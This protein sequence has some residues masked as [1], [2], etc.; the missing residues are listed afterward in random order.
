M[1]LA[2]VTR[3]H[4][5]GLRRPAPRVAPVTNTALLLL[6]AAAAAAAAPRAAAAPACATRLARALS[7]C[8]S[9]VRS[10]AG[11]LAA[12]R[13]PW[14]VAGELRATDKCCSAARGIFSQAYM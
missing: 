3:R 11:E 13:N 6:L 10:I 14:A 12:G 8:R 2:G 5:G 1:M 9:D 4:G 7:A